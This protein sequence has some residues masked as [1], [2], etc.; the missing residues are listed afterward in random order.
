VKIYKVGAK[1]PMTS[2]GTMQLNSF[3][4]WKTHKI[5]A[6]RERRN[7]EDWRPGRERR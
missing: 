6:G 3:L 2:G 5:L 7:R 1:R 4:Y